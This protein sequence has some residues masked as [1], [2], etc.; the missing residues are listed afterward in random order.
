MTSKKNKTKKNK[1]KNKQKKQFVCYWYNFHRLMI[2]I[3]C[4]N[5]KTLFLCKFIDTPRFSYNHHDTLKKVILKKSV[6]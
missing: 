3:A 6:F 5:W 2:F 1:N 4:D